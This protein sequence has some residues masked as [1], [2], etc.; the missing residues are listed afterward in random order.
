L[1]EKRDPG[2]GK[3]GYGTASE[4]GSLAGWSFSEAEDFL[5][6]HPALKRL[7]ISRGGYRQYIFKDASEVYIR[8]NGEI[9]R[10]P[11]PMYYPDGRRIKGYRINIYTGIILRSTAWHNILLTEQEWVKKDDDTSKNTDDF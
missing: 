6:S 2:A 5:N 11:R 4:F 8:P 3:G 7:V 9:I 10:L 1:T